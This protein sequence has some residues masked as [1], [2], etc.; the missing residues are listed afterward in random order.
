[1]K[2]EKR[3]DNTGPENYPNPEREDAQYKQQDEFVQQQPNKTD[4][5]SEQTPEQTRGGDEN[6]TMGNP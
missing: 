1:M 3:N 6:E 4:K 5:K 2:D